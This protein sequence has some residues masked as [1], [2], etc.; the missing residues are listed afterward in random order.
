M[1]AT[2]SALPASSRGFVLFSFNGIDVLD[3]DGRQL[4][5]SSVHR[6]LRPGG[7]FV[8]ATLNK[9]HPMFGSNPG[10]APE[11]TWVPGS[12]LPA[13]PKPEPVEGAEDDT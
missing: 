6:V 12:L 8:F 11:I 1:P 10:S 5:L 2:W 13:A 7:T 4:V 9:D 3:H